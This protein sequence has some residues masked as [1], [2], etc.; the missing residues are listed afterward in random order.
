MIR[1][2][3]AFFAV[4]DA[5]RQSVRRVQ[6]A[7]NVLA[8]LSGGADSV[9]LLAALCALQ[10][11]CALQITAVHVNHHLRSAADDDE[12]FC[13]EL[14]KRWQVPLIVKSVH[15]STSGSLEAAARAA[16]YAAFDEAL[17]QCGAQTLALAHHMDDQAETVLMHLMYGAG[18]DGLGGMAE[19]R[20]GVWRPLLELRRCQLEAAL[21]ALDQPWRVDESNAD[22]AYMRNYIRAQIVPDMERVYPQAVPA[23]CR[24]GAIVRAEGDCL[25]AQAAAW[26]SQYAAHDRW[27][28][29]LVEPLASEHP[30]MQRR[31]L[32]TYARQS[33]LMLDFE[34]TEALRALIA[35]KAGALVNLPR[36]WR[37]LRTA[38]RLHLLS[39]APPPMVWPAEALQIL[40]YKGQTGD[41][42]FT[43]AIPADILHGAVLRTR[44]RGDMIHPFGMDGH[45]KLKDYLISRG[46]DRPFRSDW[47]LLCREHEVLWAIGIGASEALRVLPEARD[48]L[49]LTF[50]GKLPNQI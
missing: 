19:Y 43:Q 13:R 3:D 38:K 6:P 41:G 1:V 27:R 24:A 39:P 8:G 20:D 5:V 2:M 50:L 47:P 32:R 17:A 49:Y 30:A 26:I 28:F 48:V 31:I 4:V 10:E 33:G 46:V 21:K 44:Q 42:L 40:P 18:A 29:L 23:I 14:C 35:Q 37:A 22:T 25:Q 7:P 16:R 36:D 45:M 15:V 12:Q 9:A 34:Q 11:E